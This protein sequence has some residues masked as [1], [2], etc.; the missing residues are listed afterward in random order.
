MATNDAWLAQIEEEVLDPA[1]PIIDTHHHL[2]DQRKGRVDRRYLMDELQRDLRTGHNIVATVFIECSAMY[3]ADGLAAFRPVG[4]VEFVNG[5][6]A[7]AASGLYGKTKVAAGIM[8]FADLQLGSRVK[9]VLE[10]QIEVAPDRFRGI[11][12][13]GAWDADPR[14]TRAKTPGLFL[15]PKFREGFASLASLGLVFETVCRHPQLAEVNDLARAFPDTSFV[16]NHL[17]GVVGIGAYAGKRDEIFA[18]WSKSLTALATCPNIVVKLGGINMDYSGF[19]WHEKAEPPTSEAAMRGDRALLRNRDRAFRPR[20]LHVRIEL[21][22]RQNQL[23][24]S[25]AVERLQADDPGL[26]R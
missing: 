4:E 15:D 3:R 26:L 13:T 10:A 6:A 5:V 12:R 2:W 23:Q 1:L 9:A 8:G 14:V 22:G 7:M 21:P 17:G 11:R 18:E 25:R 24:L 19:G 16:L 20:P